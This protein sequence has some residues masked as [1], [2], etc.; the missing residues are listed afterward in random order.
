MGAV[1][2]INGILFNMNNK[3]KP[4]SKKIRFEV[5]KRDSFK[6]QYCGR[7]APD[8]VLQVDHIVP[9]S[10]GGT[11]DMLNLVT[12]C[13][14]CNL[15]KGNRE[16]NDDS[17]VTSQR[18]QLQLLA[19]RKEQIEMLITWKQTLLNVSELEVD[20]INEYIHTLVNT[21][22]TEVG[23]N[24]IKKLLKQYTFNEI[25]EAIDISFDEYFCGTNESLENAI[26]K[27]GGICYF[28][29]NKEKYSNSY[30]CN[31]LLKMCNGKFNYINE[32]QLKK[33]LIDCVKTEDDFNNVKII[34]NRSRNWTTLRENLVKEFN[35]GNL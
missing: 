28:R 35:Y 4:L 29:K 31:Y 9:V 16:L 30:Y 2:L 17:I 24:L 3:R 33:M 11:N 10:K 1:T 7:M 22:L 26:N 6:C 19:E 8:V 27:I 32:K 34:I 15:G 13:K 5:F 23:K 18:N 25:I 12:S 21:G 20:K 14:E